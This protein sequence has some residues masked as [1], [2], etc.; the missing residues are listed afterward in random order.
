MPGPRLKAFA[1]KVFQQA[2]SAADPERSVREALQLTERFLVVRGVPHRLEPTSQ[3]VVI[4]LGKAAASMA[5]GALAVLGG[6]VT[7]CVVVPKADGWSDRAFAGCRVIPGAHP[8]PD[9]RSLE[10]GQ[11]LLDAVRGLHST[12]LVL[13]LLSGGGSALAEVPRESLALDDLVLTTDE[14]LRAG[15]DIWL[16]NAVRRRLSAIKGGGLARAAAPARVV[17]LIVSDVLGNP[18]PVIASGPTVEPTTIFEDVVGAVQR[19][20]VWAQLPERVRAILSEPESERVVL[21]NVLQTVI[22]ADVTVLVRAAAEACQAWGLPS[23]ICGTRYTGEA[24]EFGR[25][26]AALARSVRSDRQPWAPPVALVAGGELTVTVRGGGRGGRNTEMALAAAMSL[27]DAPGI[28]IASFAS[29][30]DDGTSGAAGAVVD[31]TTVAALRAQGIDAGRALS[32]NDSATVLDRVDALVRTGLTGTNV[33]DL[34]LAII[35]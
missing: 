28:T 22:L 31:A 26:W 4:A 25:F 24:R 2:L 34:Y 32:E 3:L 12:D 11:A 18:L 10:A 15:A 8:V 23:V 5:R 29:D 9:A 21:A 33:N 14:L 7:R 19:L 6:R 13:A 1:E 27:E 30:G 17:N 16:L 35:E 20:G